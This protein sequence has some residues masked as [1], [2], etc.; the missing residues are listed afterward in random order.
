MKEFIKKIFK[1]PQYDSKN[2]FESIIN[3][4]F[5]FLYLFLI[6]IFLPLE[7]FQNKE[8]ILSDRIS[9]IMYI[10]NTILSLA[11]ATIIFKFGAGLK[12]IK[13]KLK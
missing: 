4:L 9:F 11:I 12:I 10:I 3:L 2:K 6:F 8:Y 1:M 13:N 5:H 7:F